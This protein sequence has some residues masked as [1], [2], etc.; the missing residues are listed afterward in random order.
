MRL[1]FKYR[2]RYREYVLQNGQKAIYMV[3]Q[4]HNV[5]VFENGNWQYL[6][7]V[8]TKASDKVTPEVLLEIANSIE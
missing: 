4:Y 1:N 7:G 6:L 3:E 5:L 8:D 2:D